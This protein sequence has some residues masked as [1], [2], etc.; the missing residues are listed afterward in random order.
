MIKLTSPQIS[1]LLDQPETG[2]GYQAVEVGLRDRL[3]PRRGTVLNAELLVWDA[4]APTVLSRRFESLL[5]RASSAEADD[6]R[7]L[8]VIAPSRRAA[9]LVAERSAT[10]DD[11][12]PATSGEPETTEKGEVF[13]RF[14]AYRNDRRITP[15]KGLRPGTY[16]TTE[17]DANKVKTGTEAVERY[18]LP[19]PRPAVFRFRIDPLEGTELRRGIVQPDFGHTGGG[20]EV[21]FDNGTDDGTVSGPKVLPA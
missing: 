5:A 11:T 10:D 6:I 13:A 2:M 3:T 8:T 4:E 12:G 21:L 15:G 7:S 9:G 17:E 16:A 1:E 18:A 14:T 19:D 20:V